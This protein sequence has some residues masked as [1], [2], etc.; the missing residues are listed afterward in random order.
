M[1]IALP[2]TDLLYFPVPKV[3]CTSI[4]RAILHTT[5]PELNG[6]LPI[7]SETGKSM[8]VHKV[9]VTTQFTWRLPI[10][11]RDKRWFCV[12]RDPVKR[13]LSGYTNRLFH[14]KDLKKVSDADLAAKGL[15]REPELDEFVFRLEDY[16]ATSRAVRH[17]FLPMVNYLGRRPRRFDR[18]FDIRELDALST[19]CNEA[20]FSMELKHFQTGGKK[21]SEDVLDA[22]MR[23]KLLK[24]YAADYR[25]YGKFFT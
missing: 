17:H 25:A 9:F 21:L 19:Y 20:G 24:F 2:D 11:Q 14:H 10:R 15:V 4:K 3:A 7:S 5:R 18:I 22:K 12:V 1:P 6:E 23:D 13:F 8:H 16:M